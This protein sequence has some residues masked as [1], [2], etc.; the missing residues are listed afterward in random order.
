MSHTILLSERSIAA[1]Y[2][3]VIED[4]LF[5]LQ[6]EDNNPEWPF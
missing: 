2:N 6:F 4:N 3:E 5:D 1:I